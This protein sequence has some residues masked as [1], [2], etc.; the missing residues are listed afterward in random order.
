MKRCGH[1]GRAVCAPRPP[2][3]ALGWWKVPGSW[4]VPAGLL[5]RVEGLLSVPWDPRLHSHWGGAG[6]LHPLPPPWTGLERGEPWASRG[7]SQ[8]QNHGGLSL[9]APASSSLLLPEDPC[10]DGVQSN[11]LP[12]LLTAVPHD[13]GAAGVPGG[14]SVSSQ[15]TPFIASGRSSQPDPPDAPT[16]HPSAHHP[17]P[18]SLTGGVRLFVCFLPFFLRLSLAV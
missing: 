15:L 5:P 12:V 6:G 2:R 1:R 16:P 9:S 10:A 8:T 3:A 4:S 11:R 18:A 14:D 13:G 7:G 17:V